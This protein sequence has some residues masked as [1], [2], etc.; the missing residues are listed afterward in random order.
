MHRNMEAHEAPVPHIKIRPYFLRT[1]IFKA[2]LSWAYYYSLHH[3]S[4]KKEL[5]HYCKCYLVLVTNVSVI[6]ITRST[7]LYYI[8]F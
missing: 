7:F 1:L 4:N 2:A 6:L 3:W 5:K 8:I